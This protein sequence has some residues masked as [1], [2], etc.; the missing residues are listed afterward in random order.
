MDDTILI[1]KTL[2]RNAHLSN[3]A[4]TFLGKAPGMPPTFLLTP[5]SEQAS[6]N[7]FDFF[8]F[9]STP[10][11]LGILILVITPFH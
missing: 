5:R 7:Q 10:K 1:S 4:S 9:L 2:R 8:L 6:I 3:K 11:A